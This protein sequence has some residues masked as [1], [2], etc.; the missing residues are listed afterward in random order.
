M[1]KDVTNDFIDNDDDATNTPLDE[2]NNSSSSSNRKNPNIG[3]RVPNKRRKHTSNKYRLML[4]MWR[5]EC[6]VCCI[7][8]APSNIG[9]GFCITARPLSVWTDFVTSGFINS[10][11]KR[12]EDSKTN[13]T[14]PWGITTLIRDHVRA[15]W[16]VNRS[17]ARSHEVVKD[18][19]FY[20]DNFASYMVSMLLLPILFVANTVLYQGNELMAANMMLGLDLVNDN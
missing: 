17:T 1:A 19:L 14:D 11:F 16:E 15:D 8:K 7:N 18:L 6:S 9:N 3:H 5:R 20:E 2:A 4:S 13:T 12:P 10:K